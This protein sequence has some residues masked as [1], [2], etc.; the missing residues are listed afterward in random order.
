MTDLPIP[1]VDLGWQRDRIAAEVTAGWAEVLAGTAFINGPQVG[2]FERAFAAT[3]GAA[4]CVGVANG[5]D[6][7]EIA[8]RALRIGPGDTVVVPANTFVATAFAAL[9]C[10]ATLRLVDVDEDSLL[11]DPARLDATG[12]AAVVPVHLYGQLAPMADLVQAADDTLLVEDAAQAQGARQH[13]AALGSWGH[14]TATS[15]YPGKNLGAFGDAGAVLSGDADLAATMRQI[16]NN[17]SAVRYEHAL[18]GFNSRLDTLQAVVLSAKLAHLDAW[19]LLRRQAAARYDA[20]LTD[21][22]RVRRLATLPGNEHVWH[23]YPVR[24]ADRDRVLADLQAAGIGAAIHYPVPLHEQKA[25]ASLQ[26]G[27]FPVAEN[28]AGL[29]ERVVADVAVTAQARADHDM[30]EG[31]DPGAGPDRGALAQPERV[32]GDGHANAASRAWTT[33]SCCAPVIPG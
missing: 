30:G 13:G 21:H 7:L 23:L 24:V 12:A 28:R 17:G 26:L 3:T 33:R 10:G 27:S 25:L 4:H 15:F 29:D 32:D 20:L 6:A 19:N 9:R 1:L 11:M 16:A 2:Q 22:D 18:F 5:T 14:A 31:P 8:F